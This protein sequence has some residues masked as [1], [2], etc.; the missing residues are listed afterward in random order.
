MPS[1]DGW[2]IQV[3]SPVDDS[4]TGAS[5]DSSGDVYSV[6]YTSGSLFTT[7]A[8]GIDF[9]VSKVS[10]TNGSPV[11]GV[12]A[13]TNTDD[14]AYGIALDS[15]GDVL[16]C[17]RTLGSLYAAH[18]GSLDDYWVA[19]HSGS[20]GSLIWGV[21]LGTTGHNY[22]DSVAVDSNDDVLVTGYTSD[23]LH[24]TYLGSLDVWVTK[25]SG[26]DGSLIWEKQFGTATADFCHALHW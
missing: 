14:A 4:L 19:K 3:G 11:W 9:W 8:G 10:G 7:S 1:F 25:R 22:A 20:D 2:G 17:G 13:G 15:S 18:V 23:S 6:G 21:Q 12:Q 5:V 26:S 16:I 24:G